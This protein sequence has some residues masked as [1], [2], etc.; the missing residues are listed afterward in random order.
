[1]AEIVKLANGA[2]VDLDELSTAD[3]CEARLAVG[4]RVE[5]PGAADLCATYAVVEGELSA[6]AGTVAASAGMTSIGWPDI[7]GHGR[8]FSA[9]QL[10]KLSTALHGYRAGV[11]TAAELREAG[12]AAAWPP[13][14]VTIPDPKP[15]LA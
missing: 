9:A 15:L 6:L 14:T 2:M 8:M 11:L 1:M 4:C 12:T 5:F 7:S 3:Q 10:A 13:L